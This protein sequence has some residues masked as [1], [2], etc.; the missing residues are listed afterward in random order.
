MAKKVRASR[1]RVPLLQSSGVIR[2]L[3]ISPGCCCSFK[4]PALMRVVCL[5]IAGFETDPRATVFE[6]IGLHRIPMLHQS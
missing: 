4:E 2:I 3:P 6:P 1:L 5:S